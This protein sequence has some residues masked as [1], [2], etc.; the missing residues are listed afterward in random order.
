[1][2]VVLI[3]VHVAETSLMAAPRWNLGRTEMDSALPA[4][5]LAPRLLHRLDR[6]RMRRQDLQTIE[7]SRLDA[8]QRV[9]MADRLP[10]ELARMIRVGDAVADDLH[11][12]RDHEVVDVATVEVGE[13]QA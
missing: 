6:C 12:A 2:I 13:M 10:E 5:R 9:D 3:T 1:M 7:F 11:G 4:G 8:D